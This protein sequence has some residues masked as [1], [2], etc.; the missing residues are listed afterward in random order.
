MKLKSLLY[1]DKARHWPLNQIHFSDL[2]LLVGASGVGK[3]QILQSIRN[4]I[5]I[6]QGASLNGVKWDIQFEIQPDNRY[7][8]SGEFE[9]LGYEE[10]RILSFFDKDDR[11][12]PKIISERLT[13]ND[14]EIIK[15]DEQDIYF[16]G[17]KTIKLD[18]HKSVIDLI[19]DDAISLIRAALRRVT[20]NDYTQTN[21]RHFSAKDAQVES[22]QYPDLPSI[23]NSDESIRKK[24]YLCTLVAPEIFAE[25][26]QSFMEVFLFVVDVRVK[27]IASPPLPLP[28]RVPFV[29]LQEKGVTDWIDEDKISSGMFR[30][31]LQLAD[32][33]LCADGTVFLIDEFE[34]SLGINCID[35]LT[36]ILMTYERDLQ[37]IITSHHPYIINNISYPHWKVVTRK[38][39]VV[40]AKNASDYNLGESKHKAFTQ[41]INLDAYT[42]G[43]AA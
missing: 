37:F 42:E 24:L 23:R 43:V 39:G 4:M 31:L 36:S 5:G 13:L 28:W 41:L 3:T 27:P 40:S 6:A 15:R 16:N 33:Y 30:T 7:E 38:G 35:D 21:R 17:I 19:K 29:Q 1:H 10:D 34:N 25:I 8:W 12:P 22:G 9:N 26:K 11:T 14:A 18:P 2:T 32:L 20:F